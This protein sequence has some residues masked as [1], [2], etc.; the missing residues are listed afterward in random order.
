[1]NNVT[2]TDAANLLIAVMATPNVKDSVE[3]VRRFRSM[4]LDEKLSHSFSKQPIGISTFDRLPT[5][6]TFGEGLAALVEGVAQKLVAYRPNY[7][8]IAIMQTRLAGSIQWF[9]KVGSTN[10]VYRSAEAPP[11]LD[12]QR[13]I[14]ISQDTIFELGAFVGGFHE[15]FSNSASR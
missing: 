4:Q 8:T 7:F 15:R 3:T 14:R 5:P 11:K 2:S 6:H 1:M 10:N 9:Y 13:E 12:V